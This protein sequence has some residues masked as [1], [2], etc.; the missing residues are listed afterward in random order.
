[1]RNMWGNLY[2]SFRPLFS[3]LQLHELLRARR[4]SKGVRDK[5][6]GVGFRAVGFGLKVEGLA[7]SGQNG[8]TRLHGLRR[9]AAALSMHCIEVLGLTV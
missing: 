6:L 5:D 1:M 2:E 3:K 8:L 7:A 9:P 4:T